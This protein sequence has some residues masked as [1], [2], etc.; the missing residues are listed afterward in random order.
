MA[1][2]FSFPAKVASRCYHVYKETTWRNAMINEKVTVAIESNEAS[3]QIKPYC[4]AIQTK[5]RG[6]IW[7]KCCDS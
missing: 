1:D 3:K 5:S 7:S 4:C 6:E 2:S